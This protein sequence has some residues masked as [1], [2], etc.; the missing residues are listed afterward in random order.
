MKDRKKG[1]LFARILE[2][3][4]EFFICLMA[5]CADTKKFD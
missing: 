4:E 1:S 5:A 3:R 2:T